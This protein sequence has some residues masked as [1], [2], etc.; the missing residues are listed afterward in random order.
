MNGL[1]QCIETVRPLLNETAE[2]EQRAMVD[3]MMLR[4][5]NLELQL[6]VAR[7]TG[8]ERAVADIQKW[9]ADMEPFFAAVIV[10]LDPDHQ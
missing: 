4:Q 5:Q 1:R 8:E 3:Y 6:M 7:L 9:L 2:R 10:D